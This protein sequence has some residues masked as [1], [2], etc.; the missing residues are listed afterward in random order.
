MLQDHIFLIICLIVYWEQLMMTSMIVFP[1]LDVKHGMIMNYGN[2]IFYWEL[3][4]NE[5]PIVFPI[6]DGRRQRPCLGSQLRLGVRW[7]LRLA[8]T[9]DVELMGFGEMIIG[10]VGSM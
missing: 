4:P 7:H 2:L 5:T 9:S 8:L 10:G 3:L 1:V 6:L